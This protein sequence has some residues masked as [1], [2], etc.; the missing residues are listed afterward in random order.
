MEPNKN[1]YQIVISVTLTTNFSSAP[2]PDVCGGIADDE[3][4]PLPPLPLDQFPLLR[5]INITIYNVSS[6]EKDNEQLFK[7]NVG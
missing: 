4:P 5:F 2:T 3:L 7:Y 6:C 1:V